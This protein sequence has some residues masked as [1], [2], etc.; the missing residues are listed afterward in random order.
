MVIALLDKINFAAFSIPKQS[1]Q[2]SR[3][4][5]FYTPGC[6]TPSPPAKKHSL[7]ATQ[8]IQVR[9]QSELGGHSPTL[10]SLTNGQ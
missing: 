9:P 8:I 3:G 2:D 4:S 5:R 1:K 7:A 6:S 10:L